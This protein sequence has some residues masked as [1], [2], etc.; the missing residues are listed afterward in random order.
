MTNYAQITDETQLDPRVI[1]T[2]QLILDAFQTLLDSHLSI[3]DISIKEIAQQAGIN[4]V[5]FY[6]HF[7][8]KYQLLEFW[9]RDLFKREIRKYQETSPVTIEQIINVV[10]SFMNLYQSN[11]RPANRQ[12]ESLFENAIESEIQETLEKLPN[13]DSN[14]CIFIA[15]AIFGSATNWSQHPNSISQEKMSQQLTCYVKKILD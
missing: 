6:S 14:K 10:L 15:W 13:I 11:R 4:R 9:K 12:F 5:T 3:R 1:R 2:R 7:L 8:D